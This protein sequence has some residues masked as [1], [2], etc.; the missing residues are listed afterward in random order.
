MR[1]CNRHEEATEIKASFGGRETEGFEFDTLA[2]LSLS[3]SRYFLLT[4]GLYLCFEEMLCLHLQTSNLEEKSSVF[5]RNIG[6]HP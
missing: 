2:Y 1:E 5:H 6:I 4:V 3:W